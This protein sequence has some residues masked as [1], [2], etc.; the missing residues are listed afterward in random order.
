[1][2]FSRTALELLEVLPRSL[3]TVRLASPSY[4]L[5]LVSPYLSSRGLADTRTT[6]Q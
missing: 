6:N 2:S 3:A 4:P 1:M 5:V